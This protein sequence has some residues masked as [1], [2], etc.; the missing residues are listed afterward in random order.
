MELCK[1]YISR[2]RETEAVCKPTTLPVEEVR[3]S[4]VEWNE[5]NYD[6]KLTF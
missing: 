3:L 1:S 4:G 2:P 6:H 5:L